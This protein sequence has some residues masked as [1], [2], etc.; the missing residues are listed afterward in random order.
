M[1]GDPLGERIGLFAD[2]G[3]GKSTLLVA[4]ARNI[5]G[6]DED[7]VPVLLGK[8]EESSLNLSEIDWKWQPCEKLR[9]LCLSRHIPDKFR[10]EASLWFRDLCRSG[11]A[12]FLFDALD[13]SRTSLEGMAGFLN[14]DDARCCP[15][16]VTGRPESRAGR[17]EVFE[18]LQDNDWR[19][20]KVL[21]FGR[22]EQQRF[23]GATLSAILLTEGEEIADVMRNRQ[24]LHRH[25]WKD[26]LGIP[27]LLRLLKT[28]ATRS[29]ASEV[30][31]RQAITN[32]F[33][34]Y[35]K[36]IEHL[37]EKGLATVRDVAEREELQA[38]VV[39]NL[40]S[41]A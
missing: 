14:G 30:S 19:T 21:P 24:D 16:I 40:E 28:L 8:V 32:R 10:T 39:D 20:L 2:S 41:I 35:H 26:L 29:G 3:L 4:L 23:L 31:P 11:R 15:A 5:A 12:V 37:L 18:G 38:T 27:F 34:L 9:D 22:Q 25:Q 33:E 1:D 36:A 17:P 7:R 13:Q 6:G